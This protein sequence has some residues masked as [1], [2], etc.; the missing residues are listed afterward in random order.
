MKKQNNY[1]QQMQESS[2]LSDTNAAYLEMI[3]EQYLR[4][5]TTVT[6]KW[7]DYFSSLGKGADVSHV[8]MRQHFIELSK[9]RRQTPI[10]GEAVV[11]HKQSAVTDLIHSYRR[12]GHLHAKVDPLNLMPRLNIADL[13]L[14]FHGL[15]DA[16]RQTEF[17]ANGAV[18]L[19]RATL[20]Q[21]IVALQQT[22][23]GSIGA[24][25][26]HIAN[27]EEQRWLLERFEATK[28]KRVF[29]K[30]QQIRILE[31]LAAADGLEKYLG[32]KYVGQKRF[33]IEGADALIP[34]MDALTYHAATN[35]VKEIIV[36]M[37]HRGRLNMLV[38]FLG[39]PP[40]S[41][42]EEFEGKIEDGRSG[43]VKY[44]KGFSAN[45]ITPYGSVHLAMACNPS[46]LEA[47]DP[48]LQGSV[49]AKQWR[50][51]DDARQQVIP[52]LLH[53][54]AA[55]SS[56][57]VVQETLNMSQVPG[58]T[59]GGTLHIV[60]NNQVGFTTPA[61]S[62][63]S[64]HYCTDIAKMIDAPIFHVNGDD[65]QA[66]VFAL[67]LLYDYRQRFNKDVVVDL[68]CYRRH[69]H[70]EVDEPTMTQ[71]LMYQTIKQHPTPFKLYATKLQQQ[72][73]IDAAMGELIVKDYRAALN[74]GKPVI[75]IDKNTKQG[76]AY[77]YAVKWKTYNE[78]DWRVPIDTSV[79]KQQLQALSHKIM[80]TLDCCVMQPQV[81]K[82]MANRKKMATGQLAIDWGFSET[83][84]YASLLVE[85]YPVRI[86]GQDAQRGTFGHRH[87]V[88]HDYKSGKQY[89]PLTQ[90]SEQQAP[91]W[92]YNSIL[93]EFAALG[94]E[95]GY[96]SVAPD[97]L[98]VWEAQYGDFANG[99]QVIIDQFL[100]S[101]EQK[102]GQRSGLVLFLPHGHEG[103]GP[104]HTSARLE[105]YLQLC[106][107]HNMQ[108]CI[109]TTPAQV[110]HMLRRQILRKMR[111]PLIVMTPKSILRSPLALSP[112]S[113]FAQSKFEPVLDEIDN[114][115]KRKK[116]KRVVLCS[117]KIYYNLLIKRREMR[118]MDI[119]LVRIE[120][121]YPFPRNE[122]QQL[123]REYQQAREVVWTQE[124]PRNQ[125]AWYAMLHA[126]RAVV[127]EGQI[128][129]CVSRPAAAAP[130]SGYM[131]T[132][133]KLQQKVIADALGIMN[134]HE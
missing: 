72:Q 107:Q 77:K 55:F 124:E 19:Q 9:Q 37:A 120:Q 49:R 74:S 68:I 110:F 126:M 66:C 123:L 102:W 35:D 122:L 113:D 10:V 106:A 91:I 47:I 59:T 86:A 38:N 42:F 13:T 76:G 104:E 121:L 130:A 8:N 116:V 92:I 69:G 133:M 87:A 57:G 64:T 58:Y 26:M 7:R 41:L 99:A 81:A 14:D 83:L 5:A 60:V 128:L 4:D 52:V 46:H 132:H 108:V 95:A 90:L 103:A 29:S 112:L 34:M 45:V 100:S 18:G 28:G 127:N 12:L 82:L 43:D 51:G 96:V 54:D 32:T 6:P 125:G 21:I 48:V 109:P 105:R 50:R 134:L 80:Q 27:T 16:D 131:S 15:S 94:F 97:T 17:D 23:C 78:T 70:Q 117:G 84:A 65:P 101:G 114:N 62:G 61:Q 129:S 67:N 85:G 56:Q 3:Y 20:Q 73:V 39:K 1:L 30:E 33:S 111:L 11:A 24:E 40:A 98:V 31:K 2:V 88:V 22:Y 89:I 25:I 93:S 75:D 71:P 79:S 53:G 115:I 36:G 63:R 44:H 119:A 118:L